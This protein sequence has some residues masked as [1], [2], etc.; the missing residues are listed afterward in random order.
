MNF[1]DSWTA[2]WNGDVLHI[3]GVTDRFPNTFSTASLKRIDSPSAGAVSY[4]IEFHRDKEPFCDPDLV[5]PVHY[6][7]Q[8]FPSDVRLV[9]ISVPGESDS[10]TVQVPQRRA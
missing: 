9:T 3:S 1:K 2:E 8:A 5:G 6:F 7:E 4:Q 10:A